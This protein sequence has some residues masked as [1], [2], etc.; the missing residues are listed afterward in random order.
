MEVARSD[1]KSVQAREETRSEQRYIRPPVN[2]IETEEGLV[3]TADMPGAIK[4]KI[5]V[6]IEKGVLTITAPAAHELPGTP[7]YQEFELANYYRQFAVPEGLDE[8]KAK[9]EFVNGI[10]MLRVPKAE[11]VKPKRVAVQVG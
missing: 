11:A 1:E 8:H 9:A 7:T 10:L 2:I 6:N 3:I 5:D 4:E